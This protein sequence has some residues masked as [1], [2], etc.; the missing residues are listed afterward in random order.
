MILLT[1]VTLS[2]NWP[3]YASLLHLEVGGVMVVIELV[4]ATVPTF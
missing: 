1:L 2:K 4:I 3:L